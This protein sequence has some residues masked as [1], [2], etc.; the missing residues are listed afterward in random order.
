MASSPSPHPL[1]T[2]ASHRSAKTRKMPYRLPAFL[3]HGWTWP[4]ATVPSLPEKPGPSTRG[5]STSVKKQLLKVIVAFLEMISF[6]LDPYGLQKANS[7]RSAKGLM[8]LRMPAGLPLGHGW[9]KG[10][11]KAV[12]R[13]NLLKGITEGQ[14]CLHLFFLSCKMHSWKAALIF[15]LWCFL[16]TNCLAKCW[17]EPLS[18]WPS[19]T[20]SV[21][22]RELIPRSEV[23][24]I[25]LSS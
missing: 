15:R 3:L 2:I 24:S 17:E 18:L 22:Q 1:P 25:S 4:S 8:H 13:S 12:V 6:L 20:V 9:E 19:T 14:L 11:G 21:A 5:P 7:K 10:L 16:N 23:S